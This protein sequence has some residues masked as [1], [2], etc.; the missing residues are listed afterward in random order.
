META[1]WCLREDLELRAAGGGLW[2][3]KD[4]L[5]LSYFQ[6]SDAELSLL[7]RAG[8]GQPLERLSAQLASEHP[9]VDWSLAELRRFLAGAVR[10]GLMR[11]LVPGRNG[12]VARPQ[13]QSSGLKAV[14]RGWWSLISCRWRGIDPS[15]VL[16][17]L[18]P[19]TRFLLQPFVLTAGLLRTLLAMVLI[20]T[21][22]ETR[23]T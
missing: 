5:R 4:P 8:S 22:H 21:Q 16:Q 6:M 3:L 2:V 15:G 20:L 17:W 14:L 9:E 19:V 10:S 11:P 1:G 13:T 7:Q 18:S 23:V 12:T